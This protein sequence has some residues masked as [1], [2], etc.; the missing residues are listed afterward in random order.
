MRPTD[1]ECFST[2]IMYQV[3]PCPGEQYVYP[4]DHEIYN[5]GTGILVHYE[6]P[7][8]FNLLFIALQKIFK[9]MF[10][11]KD[12]ENYNF[13]RIFTTQFVFIPDA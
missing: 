7:F 9:K 12:N 8:S 4:G 3:W 11:T 6:Y 1:H 10:H 5:F 13:G 2:D